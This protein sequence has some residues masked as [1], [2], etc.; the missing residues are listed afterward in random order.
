MHLPRPDGLDVLNM[1]ELVAT[2]GLALLIGITQ[3][4]SG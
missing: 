2:T 3:Y 1:P 4:D